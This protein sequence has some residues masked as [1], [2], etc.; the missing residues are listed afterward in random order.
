MLQRCDDSAALSAYGSIRC[1]CQEK[2]RLD[3]QAF[4]AMHVCFYRGHGSKMS[5][6]EEEARDCLAL[7]KKKTMVKKN[8]DTSVPH[9]R[10]GWILYFIIA[11]IAVFIT[12][13][14]IT[15]YTVKTA[16]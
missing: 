7:L 15:V 4:S 12:F 3:K 5:H 14:V 11:R 6:G 16:S 10:H 8:I 1:Y 2:A 13:D 9:S